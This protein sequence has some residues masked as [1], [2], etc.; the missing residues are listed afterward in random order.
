MTQPFKVRKMNPAAW[1]VL[2]DHPPI[3]AITDSMYDAFYDLIGEIEGD[4]DLKIVTFESAN[5]DFF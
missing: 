1:R 2:I 5:P 3:N 4:P